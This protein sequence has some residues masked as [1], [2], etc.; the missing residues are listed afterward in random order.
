MALLDQIQARG[1]ES[2]EAPLFDALRGERSAA[3][4]Q[5]DLDCIFRQR[6]DLHVQPCLHLRSMS[7]SRH[8]PSQDLACPARTNVQEVRQSDAA[9]WISHSPL[10]M[11]PLSLPAT[12]EPSAIWPGAD[13]STFM[14]ASL[15]PWSMSVA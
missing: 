1:T 2:R 3:E 5:A 8:R 6:H 9:I 12:E 4:S 11:Q 10:C 7:V 13:D 15:L 14:D